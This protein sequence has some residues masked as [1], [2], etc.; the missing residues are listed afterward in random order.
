MSKN[1]KHINNKPM[2]IAEPTVT[3]RKPEPTTDWNPNHPVNAT[4]EEW[5]EHIHQIERGKF[6]TAEEYQNKFNAW[7]K[8]YLASR[9]K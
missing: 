9:M 5:W 8:E 1:Y 6:Y 2:T 7:K 4:Q 3:Y